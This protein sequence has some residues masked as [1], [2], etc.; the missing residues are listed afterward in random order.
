MSRISTNWYTVVSYPVHE[1]RNFPSSKRHF[2]ENE[3][4][5]LIAGQLKETEEKWDELMEK[6]DGTLTKEW[7]KRG[8]NYVKQLDIDNIWMI[9]CEQMK[10]VALHD[11]LTPQF[12]RFTLFVLMR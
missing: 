4:L 8:N 5:S 9:D 7:D 10:P 6:V 11:L 2:A 1:Y 12:G 3:Q